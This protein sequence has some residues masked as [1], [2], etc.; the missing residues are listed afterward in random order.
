[1]ENKSHRATKSLLDH[2]LSTL[3]STTHSTL[4]IKLLH[5]LFYYLARSSPHNNTLPIPNS[6]NSNLDRSLAESLD[7]SITHQLLGLQHYQPMQ[8]HTPSTPNSNFPH[9]RFLHLSLIQKIQVFISLKPSPLP[10]IHAL[11]SSCSPFPTNATP[12]FLHT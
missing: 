1:M 5:D 11:T 8:L 3:H 12:L 4:L 6:Q 9:S 10:S 7:S 2:R